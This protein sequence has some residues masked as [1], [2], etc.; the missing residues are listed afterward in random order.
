[1]FF[2]FFFF[3]QAEDGIRDLYVT[4]VQT[5]ALPIFAV[6][7]WYWISSN[8]GVRSTTAPGVAARS[9]PTVK[10]SG[11]TIDGT[12][13]GCDRSPSRF[14]VPDTMLPPPVS[15]TSFHASGDSSGLLLGARASTRLETANRMRS[16]SRQSSGAAST[17]PSAADPPAR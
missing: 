8:A 17:S 1:M 10:A 12:R 7:G 2:C 13:G 3:F 5:C 15:I 4:G 6:D 14:L 9:A 11:G 16:A